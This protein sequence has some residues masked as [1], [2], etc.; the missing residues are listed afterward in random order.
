VYISY[1]ITAC[2]I[3][4]V[5]GATIFRLVRR[6][7]LHG[8]YAAWWLSAAAFAVLVGLFP[9]GFDVLGHALGVSYPPILFIILALAAF[10]VRMLISDLERTR[11][12]LTQRRLV[13]RYAHMAL[14]LRHLER[15]LQTK[16]I[17]APRR[18]DDPLAEDAA[19]GMAPDGTLRPDDPAK[20]PAH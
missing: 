4:L 9:S 12:E 5:T 14:R 2:V 16:G 18:T 8:T 7:L 15:D 3:A 13:Q 17:V 11:M 1:R 20:P 6:N 10:A 19:D